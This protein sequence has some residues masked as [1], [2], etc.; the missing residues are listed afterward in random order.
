M[1]I[2]RLGRFLPHYIALVTFAE[3]VAVLLQ[4]GLF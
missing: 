3:V 1:H 2:P 4:G